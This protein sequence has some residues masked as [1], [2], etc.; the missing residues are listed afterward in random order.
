[1]NR[2]K[3]TIA[4][5][6]CFSGVSG[7]MFLGA[8]LNAGLPEDKLYQDISR[9]GLTGFEISSSIELKSSVQATRLK[10]K[11]SQPQPH[12]SWSAIK[13]I[14]QE[15]RLSDPVKNR[16][17]AIFQIIAESEAVVHGC[18]VDKVH[19]HEVGG[20][21][22]I[23]DIVGAAIGLEYFNINRLGV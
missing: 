1:M 11:T 23:I 12:R 18:E 4:Y 2:R 17:L 13:K 3:S 9:L 16:A 15:C 7:D 21:D 5:A 14:I 20:V 6:D 10:I 22:S 8:L 19:F